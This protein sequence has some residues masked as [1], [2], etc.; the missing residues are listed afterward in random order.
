M[1][2]TQILMIVLAVIIV[3]IAVAAG[4]NMFGK[5]AVTANRDAVV[6]DCMSILSAAQQYY[7]KPAEMGGG[8]R[9]FTGLA[10]AKLNWPQF[11]TN[12]DTAVGY[13]LTVVDAQ[14][15]TIAGTG[16]EN[17]VSVPVNCTI[18]YNATTG[19][20]TTTANP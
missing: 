14:N 13:T 17:T 16:A 5:S 15:I 10:L 12:T 20:T 7:K 4:I 1:G 8:A 3:G 6:G 19:A 11:N 2:Q 9:T 18:N